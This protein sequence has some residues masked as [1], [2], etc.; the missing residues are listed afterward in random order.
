MALSQAGTATA[1]GDHQLVVCSIKRGLQERKANVKTNS[2]GEE[3]RQPGDDEEVPITGD[4]A[5]GETGAS[6]LFL[7]ANAAVESDVRKFVRKT[8][9]TV[10]IGF[11]SGAAAELGKDLVR[12]LL[13]R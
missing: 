3:G 1:R 12:H 7:Q 8:L 11:I 2:S 5:P 13:N 4:P 9:F 10:P 6:D